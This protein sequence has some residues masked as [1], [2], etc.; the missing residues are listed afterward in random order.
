MIKVL[1]KI[2]IVVAIVLIHLVFLPLSV[3]PVV[4]CTVATLFLMKIWFEGVVNLIHLKFGVHAEGT[5]TEY[6]EDGPSPVPGKT[7]YLLDVAFQ[8]PIDNKLY[9]VPFHMYGAPATSTLMILVNRKDALKS[10]ELQKESAW[11]VALY[12]VLLPVFAG[13]IYYFFTRI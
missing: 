6:K 1:R 8:S 2:W 10:V 9:H 11:L 7:R 12:T 3:F 4:I 13:L 5:I